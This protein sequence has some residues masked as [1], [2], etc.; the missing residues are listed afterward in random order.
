MSAFAESPGII[1]SGAQLI[2][3]PTSLSLGYEFDAAGNLIA[4]RR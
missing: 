4:L 3:S 1:Q 2:A